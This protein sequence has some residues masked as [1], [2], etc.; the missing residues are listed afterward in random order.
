MLEMLIVAHL[1]NKFAFYY[2]HAG[3]IPFSQESAG[4]LY[5]KPD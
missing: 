2:E 5:S 1:F 4:G 3:A